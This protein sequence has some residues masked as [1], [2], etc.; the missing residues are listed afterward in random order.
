VNSNYIIEIGTGF[1]TGFAGVQ[2]CLPASLDRS[3]LKDITC[4]GD[5]WS[6]FLDVSTGKIHDG[7]VYYAKAMKEGV[8]A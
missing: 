2:T 3:N 4:I 7:A 6:K 8:T 1:G 5:A